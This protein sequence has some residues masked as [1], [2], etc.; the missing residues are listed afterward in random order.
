MPNY[1]WRYSAWP[2]YDTI[3][4]ACGYDRRT[5]AS[6]LKELV[7]IGLLVVQKGAGLAG[8]GGKTS[9]MTIRVDRL[10]EL[11]QAYAHLVSNEKARTLAS[12]YGASIDRL[13]RGET[14]S[15]KTGNLDGKEV[16][17]DHPTP[18]KYNLPESRSSDR[19]PTRTLS[20]TI[21]PGLSNEEDRVTAMATA[22]DHLAL[23][24]L[25]GY[26]NVEQGFVRLSSLD[27]SVVDEL[28]LQLRDNPTS[29]LVILEHVRIYEQS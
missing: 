17:K 20:S 19:Y 27:V 10:A 12:L 16:K 23:A 4:A 6:S 7:R 8:L 25:V 11:E 13:E 26:E 22:P 3:A 14:V 21:Q 24:K 2:S 28:A 15:E 18:L 5:V 1:P 29:S 9:R